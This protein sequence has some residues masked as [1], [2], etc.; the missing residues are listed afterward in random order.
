MS[1]DELK[2]K[3]N[4]DFSAG[5][6]D[7][8]IGWFTKAIDAGGNHVLY[9]NRSAC[10]CGLRKYEEALSDVRRLH[11]IFFR[12]LRRHFFRSGQSDH[13]FFLTL[14][15]PRASLSRRCHRR[16]SASR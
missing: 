4:A 13:P 7:S 15:L 11:R 10:Y 3:G 9:S 16:P 8:A 14:S 5:N 12:R 1:V 2:A 6:Y